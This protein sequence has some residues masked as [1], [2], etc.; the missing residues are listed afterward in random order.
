MAFIITHH[1]VFPV[2]LHESI[3][4]SFILNVWMAWGI[5]SWINWIPIC[6]VI[7][8]IKQLRGSLKCINHIFELIQ[9]YPVPLRSL[10]T[11]LTLFFKLI[12]LLCFDNLILSG[13]P[14]YV[15]PLLNF[16][17]HYQIAYWN[18]CIVLCCLLYLQT[19]SDIQYICDRSKVKVENNLR[20]W[21][22][23][24]MQVKENKIYFAEIHCC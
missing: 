13:L 4:F 10:Q 20:K 18:R 11:N 14:D 9:S 7:Y 6:H 19:I 8:G 15:V 22:L 24:I 1:H 23:E 5:V 2:F 12:R 17:K 16:I 21:F 3:Y